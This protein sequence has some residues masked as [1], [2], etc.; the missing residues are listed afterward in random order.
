[1]QKVLNRMAIVDPIK[2]N[3]KKEKPYEFFRQIYIEEI[4]NKKI[5]TE[6]IFNRIEKEVFRLLRSN[7]P[8]RGFKYDSKTTT[9]IFLISITTIDSF[10][11]MERLYGFSR[12]SICNLKNYLLMN[13]DYD[14]LFEINCQKKT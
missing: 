2:E 6:E 5:V 4:Y 11:T 3:L 1:M 10:R 9:I 8:K 12:S 14:L 13:L 7:K